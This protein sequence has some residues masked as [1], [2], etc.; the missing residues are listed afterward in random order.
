[1]LSLESL[2]KITQE[3]RKGEWESSSFACLRF[4]SKWAREVWVKGYGGY[5]Y[6]LS[7]K[8]S[9]WLKGTR[10]LRT[11]EFEDSELEEF[12][13]WGTVTQRLRVYVRILRT[14]LSG[15]SGPGPGNSVFSMVFVGSLE[16]NYHINT[17][18]SKS[19]LIVRRFYTQ[20]QNKI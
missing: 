11:L 5:L 18:G 9:R 16:H 14:S 3:W 15:H 12:C 4:W 17:C 19:L 10:I 8:T 2:K 7:Q 20:F 1:M 6:P 13:G